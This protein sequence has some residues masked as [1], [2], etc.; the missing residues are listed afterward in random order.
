MAENQ[1]RRTTLAPIQLSDKPRFHQNHY[2]NNQAPDLTKTSEPPRKPNHPHSYWKATP[3]KEPTIVQV[4]TQIIL[5]QCTRD[6]DHKL[7]L[8]YGSVDNWEPAKFYRQ[9]AFYLAV[10]TE[11]IDKI[12]KS[13]PFKFI[14][15]TLQFY[16]VNVRFE[17]QNTFQRKTILKLSNMTEESLTTGGDTYAEEPD[18]DNTTDT[19]TV[20]MIIRLG[21][22]P[23]REQ[24]NNL[25]AVDLEHQ[26]RTTVN[27]SSIEEPDDFD[28]RPPARYIECKPN[29]CLPSSDRVRRTPALPRIRSM[30]E[31]HQSRNDMIAQEAR[32][33]MKDFLIHME[34]AF[35]EETDG[36]IQMRQ[37]INLVNLLIKRYNIIDDRSPR[38]TITDNR[39]LIVYPRQG[40]QKIKTLYVG[41]PAWDQARFD[42][43]SALY[44]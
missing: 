19:P 21:L 25:Q 42:K 28:Y 26:K 33:L 10:L 1:P 20:H 41:E 22:L 34:K 18:L 29:S 16:P 40:K 27:L 12:I 13:E 30:E 11:T 39:T 44:N 7:K 4:K 3:L 9:P 37:Y 8:H 14:A 35:N 36:D 43:V 24:L 32:I 15:N 6:T 31:V 2:E 17:Y 23:T 5:E 38:I